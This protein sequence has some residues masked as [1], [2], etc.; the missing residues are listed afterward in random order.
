MPTQQPSFQVVRLAL[1]RMGYSHL[2]LLLQKPAHA[3]YLRLRDLSMQMQASAAAAIKFSGLAALILIG[4]V[5]KP[6]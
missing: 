6:N 4:E 5:T 3:A 1:M 2:L